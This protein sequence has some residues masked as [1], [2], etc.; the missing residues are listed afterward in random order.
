MFTKNHISLNYLLL[1]L[2]FFLVLSLNACVS[3]K[4]SDGTQ[5]VVS[6][7]SMSSDSEKENKKNEETHKAGM[8]ENTGEQYSI[9]YS[10]PSKA[11]LDLIKACKEFDYPDLKDALLRG[12]DP[13]YRGTSDRTPLMTLVARR[14]PLEVTSPPEKRKTLTEWLISKV[15]LGSLLTPEIYDMDKLDKEQKKYEKKFDSMV[16]LMVKYGADPNARVGSIEEAREYAKQDAYSTDKETDSY[17]RI[18]Q[19]VSSNVLHLAHLYKNVYAFKALLKHGANPRLLNLL[20]EPLTSEDKSL[21]YRQLPPLELALSRIP[22]TR[23]DYL[24]LEALLDHDKSLV[25]FA[26]YKG[27]TP[28]I[29]VLHLPIINHAAMIEMLVKEYDADIE[30]TSFDSRTPLHYA[31]NRSREGFNKLIELG[32]NVNVSNKEGITPLMDAIALGDMQ[33]AKTLIEKGADLNLQNNKGVS[34]LHYAIAYDNVEICQILLDAGVKRNQKDPTG[35]LP[36]HNICYAKTTKVPELLLKY[37]FNINETNTNGYTPMH[38]TTRENN[39]LILEFILKNKGNI[40]ALSSGKDG[41][42]MTPLMVAVFNKHLEATKFLLDNG[43]DKTLKN[44]QGRT[45]LGPDVKKNA[46]IMALLERYGVK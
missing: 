4:N 32:A 14:L 11:T 42:A 18:D 29:Y 25:N 3:A 31:I 35:W 22:T 43:A 24:I 16:G 12:A 41:I 10:N 28:I 26:D 21:E 39:L 46:K 40:N 20:P 30:Q 38:F 27:I 23:T 5:E 7:D 34:A 13:N 6:H 8:I 1:F 17:K 37:G 15:F 36:I 2:F 45:V 44:P 19:Y 33:S 9:T